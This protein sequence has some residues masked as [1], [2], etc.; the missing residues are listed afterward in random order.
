MTLLYDFGA[1]YALVALNNGST[2]ITSMVKFPRNS[3]VTVKSAYI[4]PITQELKV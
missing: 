3:G 2:D 1:S 4:D